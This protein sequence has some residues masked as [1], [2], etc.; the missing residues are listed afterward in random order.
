MSACAGGRGASAPVSRFCDKFTV[1]R[2]LRCRP[3]AQLPFNLDF[4]FRQNCAAHAH[5]LNPRLLLRRHDCTW[6]RFPGRK[7]F[8]GH[9][10]TRKPSRKVIPPHPATT[11]DV[12]TS[13]PPVLL[14]L[15]CTH[16]IPRSSSSFSLA[17]SFG[18]FDA[19]PAWSSNTIV[20]LPPFPGPIAVDAAN[21][22][23]SLYLITCC[24]STR[25]SGSRSRPRWHTRTCSSTTIPRTSPSPKGPS[26]LTPSLTTSRR[27]S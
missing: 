2:H 11:T 25:T 9:S 10:S 1:L 7:R 6:A 26:L 13:H 5:L 3:L 4:T 21:V 16:H 15:P 22:Q 8:R 24:P 17:P 18:Y 14:L 27:R 23:R 19:S 12:H 20:L